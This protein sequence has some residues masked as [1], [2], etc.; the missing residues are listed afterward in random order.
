MSVLRRQ[1]CSAYRGV[2][3]CGISV[4]LELAAVIQRQGGEGYVR[5]L[6]WINFILGLWLIFAGFTM[7][8]GVAPV[9]AHQITIG[10]IIAVLSIAAVRTP[11]R[12]LGWLVASAGMWT[13]VAPT[14]INYTPVPRARINDMAV[15]MIV[16]IL[17]AVNSVYRRA[18]VRT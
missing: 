18:P 3:T 2:T 15:G 6:S 16:L 9:M 14:L 7:A 10:T 4:S 1:C 13:M 5:A 11:N 8:R 12:L 17:G